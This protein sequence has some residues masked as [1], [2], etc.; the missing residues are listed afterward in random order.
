MSTIKRIVMIKNKIKNII[1]VAFSGYMLTGCNIYS[2]YQR[3]TDIEEID[4]LYSFVI[5][6]S[7]TTNISTLPW[8]ELF[9]DPILQSLIEQGLTRNTSLNVARL[10]VEQAEIS[11]KS[12]RLAYLPSLNVVPQGNLTNFNSLTS[13]TYNLSVAASWEVDIFGK[14]RNAKERSKSALEHSIAY[15]Q[16]I[17]TQLI[18]TIANTYYSL[19]MLDNQLDISKRTKSNWKE[20]LRAV[21]ALKKAGK[22][23]QTSVFQSEANTI[24]LSGHIVAI[25]KQIT[26]LENSLSALLAI[27]PQ[28]I[29]RGS[30]NQML[31]PE[32]LSVGVPIQLLSNRPDI[33]VAEHNL[34]QM[35]YAT[36]EA[37]SSFYPSITLSGA[38]GFSNS[39][40]SIINP[41]QMIYSVAAS[42]VQPIFNRGVIRAQVKISETKQEQALLQFK[43]AVLD[44]G[45]EVNAALIQWQSAKELLEYNTSQIEVLKKAVTGSK[46]LMKH[47]SA[48][49][50][51][52]LTAQLSLLQTELTY[53]ANKFEEI[54]GVINLYR[55]LGGGEK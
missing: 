51:E 37:R 4:S 7:D 9:T 32:E 18:A 50:L 25:E 38:A 35:F 43:Q 36:N 5:S 30:M 44:A 41:G 34:A 39:A 6:T 48:S 52:V 55:A 54:Q 45:V 3:T 10:N 27:N 26:E 21:I 49:Y 33:R 2:Q 8:K 1:L 19:L 23:N 13:Q 22:M 17:Q 14:L 29:E 28:H 47:G 15:R 11:L 24:A 42:I 20:N 16:A 12:A 40:G 46:L 31:F 53:S